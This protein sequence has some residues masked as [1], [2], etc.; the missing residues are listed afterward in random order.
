M[1]K[2]NKIFIIEK[3]HIFYI[4]NYQLYINRFT[5]KNINNS[6]LILIV[7]NIIT[8]E[9]IIAMRD[10]NYRFCPIGLNILDK[11]NVKVMTIPHH[12][13]K[14]INGIDKFMIDNNI[15]DLEFIISVAKVNSYGHPDINIINENSK[16]GE[17]IYTYERNYKYTI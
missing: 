5:G 13:S 9:T 8:L 16:F 7:K 15:K 11:S 4:D 3:E 10:A 12:G 2:D 14:Y 6:S 1:L 17:V